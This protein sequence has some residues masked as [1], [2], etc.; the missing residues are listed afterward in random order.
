MLVNRIELADG[1]PVLLIDEFFPEKP[2][3]ALH[4]ICDNYSQTNP[5]WNQPTGFNNSRWVYDCT[6][7]E[8]ASVAEYIS[9]PELVQE[10]SCLAGHPVWLSNTAMWVDFTGVGALTP[11]K[12]QVGGFLVQVF[13]TRST[14]NYNGTTFYNQRRQVLFQLP[15][16]NN[17]GWLFEGDRVL[18]GRQSDVSS[19]L[20][21][22]SI[23]M[24]Y[25]R[26]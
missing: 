23:M 18:H 17:L 6:T 26:T 16:R 5:A 3:A 20:S 10:I 25:A 15:Y 21:R 12:E 4:A 1:N 9:R 22:F 13:I 19:G 8:F 14:D 11:H 7:P 24:W 2:M